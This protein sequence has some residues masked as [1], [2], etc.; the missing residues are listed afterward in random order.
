MQKAQT[1]ELGVKSE[2]SYIELD[3]SLYYS[4]VRNELISVVGDFAV[5]GKTINYKGNTIHKGIELGINY[6]FNTIFTNTDKITSKLIYNYSDF[7]FQTGAYKGKKL[8]GVPVHLIQAEL[9]YWPNSSFYMGSNLRWQI[10]DTY[11]DHMNTKSVQQDAYY[12][13][14]LES[15]YK[16]NKNIRIFLAFTSLKIKIK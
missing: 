4:K 15:S 7:T 14:G 8:A 5:N 3:L 13:L 2:F 6:S 11:I 12:L 10:K 1:I 9:G 16:I